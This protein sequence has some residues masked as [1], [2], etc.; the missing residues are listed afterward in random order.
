MLSHLFDSQRLV[1]AQRH[2]LTFNKKITSRDFCGA[3]VIRRRNLMTGRI[4]FTGVFVVMQRRF[5]FLFS[6]FVVAI[7]VVVIV[8]IV[9]HRHIGK[10]LLIFAEEFGIGPADLRH[11]QLVAL[12]IAQHLTASGLHPLLQLVL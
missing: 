6:I 7:V 11:N 1:R 9:H 2:F 10:I 4:Q 8:F 5:F 12:L 3:F